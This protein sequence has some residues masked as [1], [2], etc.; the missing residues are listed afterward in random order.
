[1]A[2]HEAGMI[3]ETS[4]SDASEIQ[5]LRG[6]LEKVMSYTSSLRPLPLVA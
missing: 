4:T 3:S 5:R 1:M 6:L 2:A